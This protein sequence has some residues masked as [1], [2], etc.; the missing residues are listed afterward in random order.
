M[1]N[2]A[3]HHGKDN[4]NITS[5]IV[6]KHTG[7]C[8]ILLTSFISEVNLATCSAGRV[9]GAGAAATNGLP[10]W[11]GPALTSSPGMGE[12]SCLLMSL[13]P[14]IPSLDPPPPLDLVLDLDLSPLDSLWEALL[15][16]SPRSRRCWWWCRCMVVDGTCILALLLTNCRTRDSLETDQV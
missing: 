8:R 6:S 3:S 15:G 12:R 7:H 5:I 13:E 14:S 16:A 1:L 11:L 2:L 10:T 9:A 4:Q